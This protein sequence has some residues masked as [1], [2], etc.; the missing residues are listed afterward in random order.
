MD[1]LAIVIPANRYDNDLRRRRDHR[2]GRTLARPAAGQ[3]AP[4]APPGPRRRGPGAG[5]GGARRLCRRHRPA[6][7][8]GPRRPRAGRA[9]NPARRD[10]RPG[11]RHRSAAQRLDHPLHR[12][13]ARGSRPVALGGAQRRRRL[14][15]V[16]R[17]H[18]DAARRG[19]RGEALPGAGGAP[20][21]RNCMPRRPALHCASIPRPTTTARSERR[22]AP[23]HPRVRPG[24]RQRRPGAAARP[25]PAAGGEQ[26]RGERARPGPGHGAGADAHQHRRC[27]HT[28]ADA[29]RR[30]HPRLRDGDRRRGHVHRTGHPRLAAR[31]ACGAGPVHPAD[32]H[33][34]RADG[35]R[36][37]LRFAQQPGRGR[38]WTGSRSAW[39]SCG[40]C[41]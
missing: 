7:G 23:R 27:R 33:Q 21:R 2:A 17:R 3:R 11:R 37:G 40:C 34:L 26:Q 20:R 32:R 9:G 25:V 38:R 31:A 41:C 18:R 13:R 14:R 12:P 29:P 10:A 30:A 1:A 35:P 6:G 22:H 28:Q 16:R 15:P 24:Q 5:R 36:R 19:G 39:A 8:G 4:R